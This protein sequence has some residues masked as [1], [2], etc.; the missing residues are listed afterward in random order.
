MLLRIL[1]L[2]LLF[3]VD[4]QTFKY[5]YEL[6]EILKYL[7]PSLVVFAAAYFVIRSFLD[8][9]VRQLR[10]E[11]K[12]DTRKA[13]IP[14]RFQAYERIALLLERIN[15]ANMVLRVN[16]PGMSKEILQTEL[17]RT[18]REEYEHNLAQQIYMSDKAWEL[19]K[20][21]KEEVL[22]DINT[23][24]AKMTEKNT[25]ADYG[26]MII[27]IHLERKSPAHTAALAFLK[28]EIRD[29]F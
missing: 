7:L 14:L 2:S 8:H 13:V 17:L 3:S 10:E 18:V 28:Q 20:G 5:M 15:P 23:A 21:A 9:E 4:E 19:V 26:Q 12:D 24:A 22:S 6:L 1:Q 16:K 27:N 25:T 11:K 29:I